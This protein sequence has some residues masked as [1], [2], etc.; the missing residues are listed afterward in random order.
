M[1]YS[2]HRLTLDLHQTKSSVQIPV[3][4]FDTAVQVIIS[5]T[6]GGKPYVLTNAYAVYYGRKSNGTTIIE[7]GFGEDANVEI[8]E[9]GTRIIYTFSEQTASWLGAVESEIRLY[10]SSNEKLILT[11]P[12]FNILVLPRAVSPEDEDNISPPDTPTILEQIVAAEGA[13]DIAEKTRAQNEI[14]R[15]TAEIERDQKE[16]ERKDAEVARALA[17]TERERIFAE[18]EAERADIFSA[19]EAARAETFAKAEEIVSGVDEALDRIIEIQNALIYGE[20]EYE[21]NSSWCVVTGI[22]TY[23]S[24]HLII[25]DTYKGLRVTSIAKNAFKDNL[26][27]K[28]AAIG[29]NIG[30]IGRSCFEG[31]ENLKSIDILRD[32]GYGYILGESVGDL[33]LTSE[34]AASLLTKAQEVGDY[35]TTGTWAYYEIEPYSLRRRV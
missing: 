13:R 22:G 2:Q 24:D 16:I 6:D 4:Q 9:D 29:R 34:N 18:A 35:L 28:S 3:A 14:A 33:I 27:I 26:Y 32:D 23:K 31:C 11:T 8:S 25:P 20:L 5:L 17:E 1:N 30:T 10:D 21:L 12:K 7:G 19:N 15:D